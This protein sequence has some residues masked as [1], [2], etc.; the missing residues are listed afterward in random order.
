MTKQQ[1]LDNHN[2]TLHQMLVDERN[3]RLGIII[4]LG[5]VSWVAILVTFYLLNTWITVGK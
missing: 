4:G 2:K 5:L 3:K 1:L